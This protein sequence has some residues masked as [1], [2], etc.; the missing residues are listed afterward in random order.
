MSYNIG[1]PGPAGGF[2]FATPQT[3]GN[4][5]SFYF[6]AGPQDLAISQMPP[7]PTVGPG[8][9]SVCSSGNTWQPLPDPGITAGL[10]Q[11]S[12]AAEFGWMKAVIPTIV[13]I[14]STSTATG[15]DVGDGKNNTVNLLN[16]PPNVQAIFYQ[17]AAELCDNY[18]TV[19]VDP[20]SGDG[21]ID[22]TDWFLPSEREAILMINNIGPNTQYNQAVKILGP[23]VVSGNTV[24]PN[25]N[26]YWTST[27]DHTGGLVKAKIIDSL[28]SVTTNATRCHVFSVRPVRMFALQEVDREYR[29]PGATGGTQCISVPTGT[30]QLPLIAFQTLQDCN[31]ALQNGDC[32]GGPNPCIPGEMD[33]YNYRDGVGGVNMKWTPRVTPIYT[34]GLSGSGSHTLNNYVDNVGNNYTINTTWT[35]PY[36]GITQTQPLT[37]RQWIQKF[38]VMPQGSSLFSSALDKHSKWDSVIGLPWFN[39]NFS[40]IDAM[41]NEID[42]AQFKAQNGNGYLIKIWDK[43]KRLLGSWKYDN[44]QVMHPSV[45]YHR[46]DLPG[47]PLRNEIDLQ[48]ASF[49]E[50]SNSVK[51][52]VYFTC[53]DGKMPKMIDG[54]H[55]Y[56]KKYRVIQ[57]GIKY[58]SDGFP[59]GPDINYGKLNDPNYNLP[60]QPLGNLG[61]ISTP[62]NPIKLNLTGITNHVSLNMTGAFYTSTTGTNG[63]LAIPSFGYH[64]DEYSADGSPNHN[65]VSYAYL[66]IKCNYFDSAQFGYAHMNGPN[67]DEFNMNMICDETHGAWCG[68]KLYDIPA[69]SPFPSNSGSCGKIRPLSGIGINPTSLP[70][71]TSGSYKDVRVNCRNNGMAGVNKSPYQIGYPSSY[72]SYGGGNNYPVNCIPGDPTNPCFYTSASAMNLHP[73]FAQYRPGDGSAP[74]GNSTWT[75]VTWYNSLNNFI[76]DHQAAPKVEPNMLC[77][78]DYWAGTNATGGGTESE[79]GGRGESGEYVIT[80]FNINEEHISELGG[81]KQLSVV[82]DPFATFSLT[83]T[84]DDATV[85]YYDFSSNTFSTTYSKLS[86]EKLNTTGLYKK[87][88]TFPTSTSNVVYSVRLQ[89]EPH[90]D[91]ELQLSGVL[92]KISQTKKIYQYAKKKITFTSSSDE[93]T[94]NVDFPT[95]VEINVSPTIVTI[96]DVLTNSVNNGEVEQ[97]LSWTYTAKKDKRIMIR[98]QP[99]LTDFESTITKTTSGATDI[100]DSNNGKIITLTDVDNLYVGIKLKS[101]STGG[102]IHTEDFG[103]PIVLPTVT[104]IDTVN[105]KITIDVSLDSPDAATLT[106]AGFGAKATN[107][108]NNTNFQ[109]RDLK[110]TLNTLT[111]TTTSS[112]EDSTTIPVSSIEGITAKSLS[113]TLSESS[114]TG[115]GDNVKATTKIT[116]IDNINDLAVGQTIV[117]AVGF[118]NNLV[119]VIQGS[120]VITRLIPEEKSIIV[121]IPQ[122][123]RGNTKLTFAN[124]FVDANSIDSNNKPYV[125]RI[126][127]SNIILNSNQNFAEGDTLTFIGSSNSVTIT[128]NIILNSMGENNITT[129]LKID[130]ILKIS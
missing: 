67:T 62:S 98:R 45:K 69:P 26:K 64:N 15:S 7:S 50:L 29:C 88:I 37:A 5:T 115:S 28:T 39:L 70:Y 77:K 73:W 8:Y 18:S 6:E 113:K 12:G 127:G 96:D 107:T 20:V 24:Y 106:F 54:H 16:P 17:S 31:T 4:N 108:F 14:P 79:P 99:L 61:S 21:P 89:A 43:K 10:P 38:W 53:N 111:T 80:E 118:T 27:A 114:F 117:E 2:I 57:Y 75:N 56:G 42:I 11:I 19:G 74:G 123:F 112:V 94:P 83:I 35:D 55:I 84:T 129:D 9:G 109:L 63:N 68:Q 86:F 104:A 49:P 122:A 92:S 116:F 78:H 60:V 120:P 126:E 71:I 82:G 87:T 81:V 125:E 30:T 33:C 13:T 130:N 93:T 102:F 1:D 34:P 48:S 51:L 103:P 59:F 65:T 32:G 119:G 46:S 95:D 47:S 40:K 128:A 90:F 124:T 97:T 58:R 91:T 105:K 76:Y 3:P 110:A 23:G 85:K 66:L 101:V 100:S 22:Y 25:T 36:T 41:G 72:P 52:R 121:S 44:C